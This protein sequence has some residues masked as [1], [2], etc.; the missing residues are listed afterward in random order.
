MMSRDW[1]FRLAFGAALAGAVAAAILGGKPWFEAV[2]AIAAGLGYREWYR[3]IGG[4]H[5]SS[6][7]LG[8]AAITCVLAIFAGGA[9]LSVAVLV[10]IC[11]AATVG[12]LEAFESGRP[13]WSAGGVLYLA[14]PAL[15]LV[16]LREQAPQGT[17][18][19]LGL[20]LA[21]W[22][23]DTGALIF[24]KTIGGP[25]LVP[26]ISPDKT[27]AGFYGGIAAAMAVEAGFA[28]AVG[29]PVGAG[30]LLGGGLGLCAHG[31]DLL[32]SWFKRRFRV[33][34]SGGL[35]PGHGGMLDRIDSTLT[36]APALAILVF[37][38]HI[39]PFGGI[40]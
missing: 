18:L 4:G 3:M 9:G 14:I 37:C 21:I 5:R 40:V 30:A 28:G 13:F 11:A 12:V 8:I 32:E 35:I 27:W 10:L 24:G 2:V 39:D 16:L 6:Q 1:I 36:A 25:K 29:A 31:G 20:F 38:F 26:M 15:A 34:D 22:A 23:T 19:L 7:L 33:K 17:W